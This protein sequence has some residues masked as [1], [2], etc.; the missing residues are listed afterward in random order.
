MITSP[1]KH[2]I[3]PHCGFSQGEPAGWFV[4]GRRI[5]EAST[6]KSQCCDCDKFFVCTR[7]ENLDI[8]VRKT[9]RVD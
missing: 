5:G 7:L 4:I 2:L 8:D 9:L 6:A 3:C 1:N